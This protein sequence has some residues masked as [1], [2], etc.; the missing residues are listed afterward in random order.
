[1][2]AVATPPLA[3]SI[4]L[5]T[6]S[7]GSYSGV[8]RVAP[9]VLL[10]LAR[11]T[12]DM[13]VVSWVPRHVPSQVDGQPLGPIRLEALPL[14]RVARAVARREAPPR[15]LLEHALLAVAA[16]R[17]PTDAAPP[18]LE[19]VN[20][21]GAHT[22]SQC[23]FGAGASGVLRAVVVHESPRHLEEIGPSALQSG[24]A[25]LRSYALR[26]FV[27]ERGRTEWDAR[28]GLDPASSLCIPNC[29]RESEVARVSALERSQLRRR[30]GYDDGSLRVVVVGSVIWRKGPDLLLAAAERLTAQRIELK[31]DLLGPCA[32]PWARQLERGLRGTALAR[33]VRFLGSVDDVYERIFAADVLALASRAEAFPLSVLEALALGTCVVA[34]NVDGI[35]EQV[36]HERSGLL[37]AREA[38]DELA[39][40]LTRVAVDPQLRAA[41]AAAG[42][43]R[44]K[45]RF[46]RS[47]QLSRWAD[48]VRRALQGPQS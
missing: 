10:A 33:R 20:G 19:V 46:Q 6:R 1:M 24:M 30:L 42:R 31:I 35:V 25:A 3:R 38:V 44:Y 7:F 21:L 22:L 13:R 26:V 15:S 29:A 9:D 32:S 12:S 39:A 41:L 11:C 47:L 37:F 4:A 36:E 16:A 5:T 8:S 23:A 14:R 34:A 43:E 27:S 45:A 48:A 28:I 40:Q 17:V 2:S 18:L